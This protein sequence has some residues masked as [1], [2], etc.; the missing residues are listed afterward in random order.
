MAKRRKSIE[1]RISDYKAAG[2]KKGD[3]DGDVLET[4]DNVLIAKLRGLPD[5]IA[6]ELSRERA[7]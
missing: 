7:S 1:F 3:L 2:V 6:E 5:S 4:R